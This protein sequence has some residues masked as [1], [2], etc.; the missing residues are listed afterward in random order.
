MNEYVY[1]LDQFRQV[2]YMEVAKA[3]YYR[4]NISRRRGDVQ[5]VITI[6]YSDVAK[7]G[8]SPIEQLAI[9]ILRY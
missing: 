1:T 2:G 6:K 8:Y 9:F 3:D 4:M 5:T 7:A